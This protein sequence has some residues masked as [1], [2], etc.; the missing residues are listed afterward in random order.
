[1]HALSTPALDRLKAFLLSD[2]YAF[3]EIVCGHRDL[4]PAVH[5][6]MSYAVCGLTDKLAWALT[7]SGFESGVIRQLRQQCEVRGIDLR[8]AAGRAA[9]DKALDWQNWRV[10]RGTFKS[11]VITH[12]GA[13]FCATRDPNTTAKLVHAVDE[14]A[15]AMCGQ[16]AETV[17]SGV[18]RDLFPERVPDGNIKELVTTKHVTF[19]GRNISHPQTT[20]Q[21]SGYSS[22][23]I[24]GHYDTFWIDDLVVGGPGGNA[25]EAALP[26]VHAWLRGLPGFYMNTRRVRQIHVGTRYHENDDHYFLT[27]GTNAL[28]CL[29]VFVPVEEHE[30]EVVNILKRGTPT[31]PTLLSSDKITSL[32]SKVLSGGDDME[33]AYSWRCNYLLDPS[34]AGGKMFPD[35]I[36]DDPDRAWMGPFPHPA[37]LTSEQ[38]KHR[39]LIARLVR[40]DEGRVIGKDNKP[41]DI[42]EE[43]YRAKAKVLTYDPWK[44]LDRVITLDPA[45][46][47][48]GNNWAVTAAGIDPYGVAFQLETQSGNNGLEG[49]LS[50]LDALERAYKPRIIGFGAGAYQDE[51]VKNL[52]RTDARL[53][54][55]RGR[56]TPL[57]E[58]GDSKE[59]RIRNGAA[60]PYKQFKLLLLP[61]TIVG[62]D[63]GASATRDEMRA[64]RA[65]KNAVD[66][67]L[68][69]LW[70]IRAVARRV[71]T[72]E[73]RE[74]DER[75]ARLQ[76]YRHTIDP[77]LG[78]PVAA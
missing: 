50:A 51:I 27:K 7:Q 34:A 20:I 15:W 75:N 66:G 12:G 56:I 46:K 21:A 22:K 59:T 19:G 44:D 41:L 24:G 16:V 76:R 29:T 62:D 61:P 52:M 78:V 47:D 17:L 35:K 42:T 63:C 33:G 55:M 14:K 73:D 57:K 9:L 1:M 74:A 68:D 54:R 5:M 43:G 37:S 28:A 25:T 31:M 11:S 49:W 8:T 30:G 2:S 39:F 71:Q 26:G 32:Q 13:T 3:T 18:F 67:I 65:G 60:E 72:R 69:T 23:D 48:G 64:Y 77:I 38:Y 36:V 40:D 45:W 4:D 6:A 10:A 70:M 58:T 53:R